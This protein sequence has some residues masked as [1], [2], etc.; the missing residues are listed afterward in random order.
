MNAYCTLHRLRL[1][2]YW[3]GMYSYIKC[4][5]NACPGCTL[6]SPAES[7]S[8]KLAYNFQSRRPFWSYLLM[9]ILQKST[10]ALMAHMYTWLHAV[11]WLDLPLW[12]PSSMLIPKPLHWVIR[13]SNCATVFVTGLFWTRTANFLGSAVK[14]L[15]SFKSTAMISQAKTITQWWSKESIDTLQ[16]A[17][18]SWPMSATLSGL[19]WRRSSSFFM[20]GILALSPERASPEASLQ[21]VVNLL[22]QSITQQINTG[23]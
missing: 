8:S 1:W 22:F 16:K 13:R 15:T 9:C 3:P 17:S 4:I 12:N 19:P 7:K 2:Y 18:R 10:L 21:L 11:A 5:C 23:N 6:A 20:H 14:R